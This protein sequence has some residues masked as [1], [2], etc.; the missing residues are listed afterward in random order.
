MAYF[1]GSE[2]LLVLV[3]VLVLLV[4]LRFV[5]KMAKSSQFGQNTVKLA[6]NCYTTVN[7]PPDRFLLPKF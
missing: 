4:L 7:T 1:F 2:S 5:S 6:S 3:L